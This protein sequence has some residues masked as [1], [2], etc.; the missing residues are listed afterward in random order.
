MTLPCFDV[1]WIEFGPAWPERCMP[2]G[3]A[4]KLVPTSTFQSIERAVI[5]SSLA[6]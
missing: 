1:H 4:H 3:K 2:R 5:T 6:P